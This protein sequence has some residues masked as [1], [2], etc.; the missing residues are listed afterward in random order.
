MTLMIGRFSK[1]MCVMLAFMP[2]CFANARGV[3]PGEMM[4]ESYV[5]GQMHHWRQALV[6]LERERVANANFTNLWN[7]ALARYGYA[8]YCIEAKLPDEARLMVDAGWTCVTMMHRMAPDSGPLEALRGAYCELEMALSSVKIPV[9]GP[10]LYQASKR[11]MQLSPNDAYCLAERALYLWHA[12]SWV[13]GD[14]GEALVKYQQAIA[15]LEKQN[16]Q[17]DW[18]YLHTLTLLAQAFDSSQRVVEARAVYQKII[19]IEPRYQR[20]TNQLYPAFCSRNT[21]P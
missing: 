13:G 8:G 14:R 10:M 2:M 19:R 7:E 12:P 16:R 17:K 5:T 6:L 15:L 21:L 1:W 4:Y 11:S 9:Y 3:T 20:V 18:Y